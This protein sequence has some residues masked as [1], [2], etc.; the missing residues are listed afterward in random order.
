MTAS[1]GHHPATETILRTKTEYNLRLCKGG[2]GELVDRPAVAGHMTQFKSLVLRF[3]LIQGISGL[4]I[5]QPGA[6]A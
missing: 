2:D 5:G 1:F 6:W 3:L 4:G